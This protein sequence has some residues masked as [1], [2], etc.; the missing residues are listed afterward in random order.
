MVDQ[1]GRRFA[2]EARN[3]ND[4]GRALLDV[5]PELTYARLPAW[6]IFDAE[7]R[8]KY[9]LGH[10]LRPDSPDPEYLHT[11]ADLAGLAE[12]LDVPTDNL[13]AAV[14]RFNRQAERGVDEDFGRG[15][16]PWGRHVGDRR[17]RHPNLAPLRSAPYYAVRVL[18]GCLGTKG[19]P[20]TDPEGR[21]LRADGGGPI[22]GLFAAGNV[23]ASPFGFAY[24]GGGATIGPAL[25]FGWLGGAAAARGEFGD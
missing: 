15:S 12:H 1:T 9:G 3:Y 4:M 21:V 22:P 2:D 11:A 20:R 18:P 16:S 10:V 13:V 17:A 23:S 24:P 6:L 8:R 5:T 14:D 25:T 19:G 7:H